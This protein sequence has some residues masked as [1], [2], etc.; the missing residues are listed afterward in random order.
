MEK[1]V[2]IMI[3]VFLF[4]TVIHF[5]SIKL[6]RTSKERKERLKTIFIYIYGVAYA[7]IG[8]IQLEFNGGGSIFSILQ[9]ACGVTFII[10]NYFG[11]LNPTK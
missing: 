3:S 11:K 2:F 6:I 10:L 5:V 4:I 7:I 9:I 8:V 1:G